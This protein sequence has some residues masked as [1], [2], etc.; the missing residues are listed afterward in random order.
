MPLL[1][2]L[3]YTFVKIGLFSYGGGYAMISLLRYEAVSHGWMTVTEF[4][5]VVAI[6]Q[7]TPGPIAVNM[8]TFVGFR[9]AGIAGSLVATLGV[10]LP[11]FVLVLIV[12]RFLSRFKASSA[13]QS[14]LFGLRPAVAGMI[15]AAAL[16]IAWAEFFPGT[17]AL[18]FLA[19]ANAIEFRAIGICAVVFVCLTKFKISPI[20][21]IAVSAVAGIILW[22]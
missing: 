5:D 3:F 19:A 16:L 21:M 18:D 15:A 14:V 4:A 17:D 22:R 13:V 6:S 10:S 7:I 20:I 8:A 1:A 12:L 2:E 9:E 11:S